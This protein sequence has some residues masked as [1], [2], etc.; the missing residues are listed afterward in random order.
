MALGRLTDIKGRE[1]FNTVN[2][3][4]QTFH[5]AATVEE[6]RDAT[7][8]CYLASIMAL[9][10]CVEAACPAVGVQYYDQVMRIRRRLAFDSSPV[11]LE[12]TRE[13]LESTLMAY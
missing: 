6:T 8:E 9:A 13:S 2:D 12:E 3:T 10:E 1:L 4:E 5:P 7:L 11:T